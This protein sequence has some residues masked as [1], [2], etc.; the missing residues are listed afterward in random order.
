MRLSPGFVLS[1]L[2]AALGGCS[3]KP[4]Q[5]MTGTGS[6]G[7]ISFDGGQD[8]VAPSTDG[9]LDLQIHPPTFD[10][11]LDLPADVPLFPGVR[12]FVVTSQLQRDGGI[13][14]FPSGH[15]FTMAVDGDRRTA[16]VGAPGEGSVHPL[17]PLGGGAL[18][19]SE[20]LRFGLPD[21]FGT[22]PCSTSR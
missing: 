3:S 6:G 16:I 2:L 10:A 13:G 22:G 11:L 18:R 1:L 15:V 21:P 14:T 9:A 17:A 20:P 7:S 8:L 12:S 4:L 19:I 5:P